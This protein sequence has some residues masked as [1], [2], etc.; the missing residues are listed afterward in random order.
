MTTIYVVFIV[1]IFTNGLSDETI[2]LCHYAPVALYQ[3][4]T[5]EL[6]QKENE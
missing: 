2:K 3:E 1:Q 5:D 6:K 4:F